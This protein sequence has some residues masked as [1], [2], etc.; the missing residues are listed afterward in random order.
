MTVILDPALALI[1]WAHYAPP[2]SDMFRKSYR[3]LLRW[4]DE[5]PFAKFSV[6]EDE[7]PLLAVELPIATAGADDARARPRPDPGH[8]RPAARRVQGLA[9]DR[10]PRCP[11]P[12]SRDLG[13]TRRCSI[14]TRPAARAAGRRRERIASR[15]RDPPAGRRHRRLRC[16]PSPAASCWPRPSAGRPSGPPNPDL[17]IV[18]RRALRRPARHSVASGSSST[19]S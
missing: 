8:R 19:W 12:G 6:G 17:T 11:T 2:I 3:K 16:W 5:F 10:R 4:N 15:S 13:A 7:R 9:V 14:D 1:C 18:E